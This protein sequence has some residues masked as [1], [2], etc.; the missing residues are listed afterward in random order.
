MIVSGGNRYSIDDNINYILIKKTLKGADFVK[1]FTTD[2]RIFVV[3]N[4]DKVLD[5]D[6]NPSLLQAPQVIIIVSIN[7]ECNCK[8]NKLN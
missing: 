4:E 5:V 1:S 2:E 3:F 8:L 7:L 6:S